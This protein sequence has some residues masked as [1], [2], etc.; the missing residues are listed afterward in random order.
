MPNVLI[1][2]LAYLTRG[3][4]QT[5]WLSAVAIAAALTIGLVLGVISVY[6]P[7]PARAF[8]A[9][10]VLTFR[11]V[12]VLVLM[13]LAYY[14]FPTLGFFPDPLFAVAVAL[15]VYGAAFAAE[16]TRGAIVAVPRGQ[17]EA[18]I[19]LGLPLVPRLLTVI[20][21]QA[22]RYSVPAYL[23]LTIVL[24]KSTSYAAIVGAWELAYAAREIVER[25]LAPFQIFL[26]VMMF[27]FA[28]CYPLTLLARYLETAWNASVALTPG[29]S[30]VQ[31]TA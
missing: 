31:T 30:A 23:N 6:G 26:G 5:V 16:I 1:A 22:V 11:A 13:F 4:I 9:A 28:I 29:R 7:R 20:G 8:I 19:S 27:Y 3:A 14:I 10:Y 17:T 21:P 12:P 2:N 18:A 24:V 15:A 25:T